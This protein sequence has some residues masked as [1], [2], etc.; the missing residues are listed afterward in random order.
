MNTYLMAVKH[1]FRGEEMF[2][3]SAANKADAVLA[4]TNLVNTDPHFTVGGNYDRKSVRCIRKV[5]T[6]KAKEVRA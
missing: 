3:V 1:F 2:E 6:K 5:P 4:G